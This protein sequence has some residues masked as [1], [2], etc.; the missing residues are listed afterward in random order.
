MRKNPYSVHAEESFSPFAYLVYRPDGARLI[1]MQ[2]PPWFIAPCSGS[3]PERKGLMPIRIRRHD[4]EAAQMKRFALSRVR[5]AG[6]HEPPVCY[7]DRK[8]NRRILCG[9]V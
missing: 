5:A 8:P 3:S 7:Q 2:A 9:S 4:K 6:R 1:F